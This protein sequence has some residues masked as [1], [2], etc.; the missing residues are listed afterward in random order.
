MAQFKENLEK[1]VHDKDEHILIRFGAIISQGL[2]NI[3]G[4]NCKIN[5]VS[6]NGNNKM[7]AIIG[8][9]LFTQYYYWFPM[10]HFVNL[11]VEPVILFGVD[12][13]LKVPK[14]FRVLSSAKPSIYGYPE[15][16]KLEEKSTKKEVATA[17]L[18]T[19]GRAK[20]KMKRLGTSTSINNPEMNIDER[21]ISQN[22]LPNL[23][24]ELKEK[25]EK[26]KE[27][28]KIEE[29]NEEF[30]FNPC[31]ILPKQ[32]QVIKNVKEDM[33]RPILTNR[34]NGFVM[35]NKIK[36]A[37]NWEYFDEEIK[38]EDNKL[39]ENKEIEQGKN[40]YLPVPTSEVEMPEEIDL[41]SLNKK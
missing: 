34:F 9:A 5:L 28:V 12:S 39:E 25:E 10:I 24:K 33:F 38:N 3:G 16:A 30:I 32:I 20:N 4:R 29:P 7:A 19:V 22:V 36:E 18:S 26:E 17:V 11:A 6:S 8:M 1:V 13:K 14:N 27:I 41:N 31:R 23:D 35:L 15:E 21:S 2:L 40:N 37:E